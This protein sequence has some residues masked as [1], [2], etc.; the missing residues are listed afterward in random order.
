AITPAEG[1]AGAIDREQKGGRSQ[2]LA[3]AA[4]SDDEAS[5]VARPHDPASL[6]PLRHAPDHAI[7]ATEH[8]AHVQLC[9]AANR[10]PECDAPMA[11]VEDA[12]RHRAQAARGI[13]CTDADA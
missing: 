2:S 6:K 10:H 13:P 4:R 12:P 9:D 7:V 5:V 11:R 3:L 8:V 1:S